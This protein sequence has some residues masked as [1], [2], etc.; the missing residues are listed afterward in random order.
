MLLGEK[1]TIGFQ[2]DANKLTDCLSIVAILLLIYFTLLLWDKRS[3]MTNIVRIIGGVVF[4]A[5]VLFYP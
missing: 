1:I 2:N 4:I 3:R 5:A